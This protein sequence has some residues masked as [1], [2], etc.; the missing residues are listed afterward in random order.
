MKYYETSKF[1]KAVG[2][3]GFYSIIAVCIV[4]IGAISWFAVS[5]YNKA[6]QKGSPNPQI[7]ESTPSDT[8]NSVPDTEN[9]EPESPPAVAPNESAEAQTYEQSVPFEESVT[10][11]LPITAG[12]KFLKDYSDTTLQ[13]SATYGDM[14]L[15]KGLDI[16]APLGSE[17]KAVSSGTVLEIS[18]DALL[19]KC[20]TVEH[21]GSVT[22][23]YCGFDTLAV[24][25]GESVLAGR[26]L[27]TLG[28]VP[29][30]CADDSHIHIEIKK[31]GK[32]ISPSEIFKT[33]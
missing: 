16:A 10:Y 2:S 8:K 31:D 23:K 11:S 18:D 12:G 32:P 22:V 7:S 21:A 15:H 4:A 30:E 29:S 26:V 19:G 17:I 13:Y 6:S 27:G 33:E 28:T 1:P 24:S 25:D 9:K 20:V 3:V 5:R 14:R